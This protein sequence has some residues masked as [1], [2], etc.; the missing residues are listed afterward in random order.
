MRGATAPDIGGT[1][2]SITSALVPPDHAG[3]LAAMAATLPGV[4][5]IQ[6]V[7]GDPSG[8]SV[9]G[10]DQDQNNTSLNGL[11]SDAS[12]IPRDANVS[13]NLA[14][15]PYDVS[16]GQ[17]SGGRINIR[18]SPGSNYINR[19]VERPVQ[20]A[21]VGVD[22]PRPA[23]RS[24]SSTRTRTSAGRCPGPFALRQGLL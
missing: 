8:I 7:N 9:L 5:F 13:V 20:R 12:D 17:F 15:S 11:N 6:G 10:L 1:E 2:K 22:R 18:T 4:L 21:A 16:Q 14:T 19:S 23:A 3:D 24:A